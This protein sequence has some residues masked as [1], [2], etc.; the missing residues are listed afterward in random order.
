MVRYGG[1]LDTLKSVI[2]LLG[3]PERVFSGKR[4]LIEKIIMLLNLLILTAAGVV[5]G[6]DQAHVFCISPI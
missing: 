6:W 1:T 5:F 2:R 4:M 3:P